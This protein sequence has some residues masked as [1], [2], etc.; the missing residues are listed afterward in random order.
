[1]G[2]EVDRCQF[3]VFGHFQNP[4]QVLETLALKVRKILMRVEQHR[5]QA[6]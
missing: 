1:L 4:R 6:T 2:F 5:Q 3:D